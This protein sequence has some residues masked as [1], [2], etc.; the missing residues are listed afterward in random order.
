M[1]KN[2]YIAAICGLVVGIWIGTTFYRYDFRTWAAGLPLRSTISI[3]PL[4][5]SHPEYR[6]PVQNRIDLSDL[7]D[8]QKPFNPDEY[9]KSKGDVFDQIDFEPISS[10]TP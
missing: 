2:L 7:P 4:Q 3:R 1:N 10:P 5:R 8:K 6:K 9:L